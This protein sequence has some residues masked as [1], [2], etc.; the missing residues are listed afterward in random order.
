MKCALINCKQLNLSV[1]QISENNIMY[2]ITYSIILEINHI[3]T[4]IALIL[5]FAS[6]KEKQTKKRNI[7][8]TKAQFARLKSLYM[9]L[10]S[11]RKIHKLP[12]CFQSMQKHP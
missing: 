8:L 5:A 6:G 11:S 4:Q 12:H 2:T 1:I 9:E 10:F 3:R 7:I